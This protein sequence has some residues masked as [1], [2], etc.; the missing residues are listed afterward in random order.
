MRTAGRRATIGLAVVALAGTWIGV[1]TASASTNHESAGARSGDQEGAGGQ[2]DAEGQ[3]GAGGV[4]AA[5]NQPSGNKIVA[6][7][8][9]ADGSLTQAGTYPTGGSGDGMPDN[10]A[11]S[12]ILGEESPTNH[13]S[14]EH[15]FLFAA[16]LGSNSIS[17][18]RYQAPAG[19]QLLGTESR[20][21]SH[22][23]SLAL[24]GN[25]LYVLNAQRFNCDPGTGANITGFRLGEDGSLTPIPGSTRPLSGTTPSGCAQVAFNP[26]GDVLTVT[27][28]EANVID[29]YTI[30]RDGVAHGPIVNTNL[31]SN[32]PFGTTYTNHGVLLATQNFQA[33][34]GLG[35]LASYSVGSSGTLTRTSPTVINGQTDTCWVVNTENGK[36][37]YVTSAFSNFVS[38]YRVG[39][40]GSL[41]LLNP[42]AGMVGPVPTPAGGGL[43]ETLSGNGRYLYARNVFEGSISGFRVEDD[44]SLT[45]LG[46]VS[47][48]ANLPSGSALGIAGR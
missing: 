23:T 24:R 3:G 26:R 29:T 46:D 9:G 33:G 17:V 37:A 20:G 41:A 34:P 39:A 19:L 5:S 27:E 42:T 38:S 48:P 47:D 10:S 22:P 32:G 18:F 7:R 12:V 2:D 15:R 16:N 28:V 45:K 44:G 8:R 13:L 6:F 40:D 14:H 35:G 43:D 4:F 36:Y 31:P 11:N 21:I 1:G 30:D 25:V